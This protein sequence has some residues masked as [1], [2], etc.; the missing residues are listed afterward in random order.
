MV[1]YGTGPKAGFIVSK[2]IDRRSVVR[3]EV[4]RRL[5]D[6]VAPLLPRLGNKVE[7]VF[8]AKQKAISSTREELQKELE[9]A[10]KRAQILS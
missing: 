3:H 6:A 10:L 8:L 9:L 7:L 4:K 2:K 5:A 1:A